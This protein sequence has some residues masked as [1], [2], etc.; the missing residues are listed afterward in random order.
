MNF[1][2]LSKLWEKLPK[3]FQK[4]L[5]IVITLFVLFLMF[6]LSINIYKGKPTKFLGFEFNNEVKHD[7]IVK[8]D[9]IYKK[10]YNDSI[11]PQEKIV[12]KYI[13]IPSNPATSTDN[14][15]HNVNGN[16]NNI[17]VNGDVNFEKPSDLTDYYKSIMIELIDSLESTTSL[18]KKTCI[19]LN[20]QQNSNRA[21]KLSGDIYE[22][23]KSKKYNVCGSGTGVYGI[24]DGVII[25]KNF[26]H[27]MIE[28]K[29]DQIDIIVK[30]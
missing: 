24:R 22:F 25:Q 11:K 18:G 19:S 12:Y 6:V 15:H 7:S 23:L 10:V 28:N 9:T 29:V 21:Q 17:G 30:F 3:F 14:S 8:H 4:I 16:G 13:N 2:L 26:F 27:R 1:E 5:P 20:Y